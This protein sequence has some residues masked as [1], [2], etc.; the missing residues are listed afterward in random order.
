MNYL[1]ETWI[2]SIA[3]MDSNVSLPNLVKI[4]PQAFFFLA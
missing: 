4:V 3:F 1:I 2:Y